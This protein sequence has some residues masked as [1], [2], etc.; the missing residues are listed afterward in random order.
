MGLLHQ[1]HGP[2][3]EDRASQVIRAEITD[4]HSAPVPCETSTTW[5]QPDHPPR[6]PELRRYL[7]RF[8]P[9]GHAFRF[10]E[11]YDRDTGEKIPF[12]P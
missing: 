10:V 5:S 1:L 12:N 8:G 11:V 6:C 3:A 4:H 7:E 2:A 9:G